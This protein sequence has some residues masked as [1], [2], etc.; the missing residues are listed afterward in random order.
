MHIVKVLLVW[1][2][3][4]AGQKECWWKEVKLCALILAYGSIFV[5][6]ELYMERVVS[7]IFYYFEWST[8][9]IAKLLDSARVRIG[10]DLNMRF[11]NVPNFE[12]L[13]WGEIRVMTFTMASAE[14]FDKNS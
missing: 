10:L 1:D 11:D 5:I 8:D 7:K 3:Q 2:V 4:R 9:L 6:Q 14:F 12:V 13:G